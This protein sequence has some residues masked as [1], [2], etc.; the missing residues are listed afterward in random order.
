LERIRE[1]GF[2]GLAVLMEQM[3]ASEQA[4]GINAPNRV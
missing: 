2:G 4:D 1:E 3:A